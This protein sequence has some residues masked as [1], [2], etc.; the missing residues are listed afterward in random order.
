[1]LV[2]FHPEH[3]V[4]QDDKTYYNLAPWSGNISLRGPAPSIQSI[5]TNS[6]EL[7]K[8]KDITT[9]DLKRINAQDLKRVEE[10]RAA[11]CCTWKDCPLTF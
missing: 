10:A 1:M 5:S 7:L 3:S 4:E 9:A 2:E 6:L 8:S 11:N